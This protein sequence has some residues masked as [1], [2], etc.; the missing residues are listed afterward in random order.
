MN[1]MGYDAAALGNHEFDSGVER[2]AE[3]E[4]QADFPYL[5]AN[6]ID[7]D[8]GQVPSWARPWVVLPAGGV[9]VGVLGLTYEGTPGAVVAGAV[10]GLVFTDPVEAVER[11]VPRLIEAGAQ[12]V[13]LLAH[14]CAG[15]VASILAAADARVDVAFGAHCHELDT[16]VQDGVPVVSSGAY[17]RS[18]STVELTVDPVAAEVLEHAVAQTRIAWPTG[19]EPPVAPDAELQALVDGW[20][21]ELDEALGETV[22]HTKSGIAQGSWVQANCVTDAWLWAFP[23][24]EMAV[25]NLGGLRQSLQP[26]PVTLADL[27]GMMPFDNTLMEVRIT[28]EQL[29][30]NIATA[31]TG[32]LDRGPAVAGFR[33]GWVDG[34]VQ[35]FRPDGAPLELDAEY[36]VMIQDFIYGSAGYLFSEQDPDPY[37]TARNYRDPVVDWCRAHAT[38]AE[39]PLESL[40]DPA[41]RG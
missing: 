20:Q 24:A 31:V 32:P 18:Y 13:V 14:E 26:G 33:Y 36:R 11:E 19:E 4:A 27:V 3:R 34:G 37:D 41:P 35:L 17:W 2:L 9:S 38:D 6:L 7:A 1:A 25:Q 28:G 16:A 40:I 23:D 10:E 30:Q 12:V 22:A 21:E 29:R 15:R 39:A 5:A 8:S